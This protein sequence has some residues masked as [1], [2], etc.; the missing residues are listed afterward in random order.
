MISNAKPGHADAYAAPF[1]TA[2]HITAQP[3]LLGPR[4]ALDEW[5]PD[6][7]RPDRSGYLVRSRWRTAREVYAE[8]RDRLHDLPL[9]W[10]L[11]R[12]PDAYGLGARWIYGDT[13]EYCSYGEAKWLAAAELTHYHTVACYPVTGGSEGYFAHVELIGGHDDARRQR[14]CLIKT[15]DG[16]DTACAL[17]NACAT[18]LGA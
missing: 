9:P 2:H 5:I 13:F 12:E 10:R 1:D 11:R 4:I 3:V 14:I 17:A 18:L 6:P 15:F 7:N 16:W 8:L